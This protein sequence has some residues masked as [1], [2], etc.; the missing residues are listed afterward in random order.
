[1]AGFPIVI[2]LHKR[3]GKFKDN[4]ELRYTLRS[5][6]RHFKG[7]CQVAIVSEKLPVW[8]EGIEHIP[9]GGKGLKTALIRAAERF[10]G[11]FFWWYDDCVLLQDQ[12][13]AQLMVTPACKGWSTAK[14]AWAKSLDSIKER[15]IAEGRHAIDF[16]RPH[17]PY[18]LTKSMIDEA[19]AD[20][21]GMGGKFP[22]ESWILS[23]RGWPRRHA[24]VRQYYG[25]F[26]SPP[27]PASVFMNWCDRGFTPPLLKWLG[28]RF[29][30]AGRYEVK[31]KPVEIHCLRF[32]DPWWMKLCAPTLDAWC[33][34][35]GYPLRIWGSG[36]QPSAKFCMVDMLREFLKGNS[37]RMALVDA[38]VYVAENAPPLPP[39][40]TGFCI[41]EDMPGT[42]PQ[43]YTRWC[44]RNRI[45]TP[46]WVYRNSG[47]WVCDREAARR[48]LEFAVPPFI[49]GCQ[50]QHQ[51]NAWL[52]QA[53]AAGMQV[54]FLPPMWN[55]W[56]HETGPAAFCHLAGRRKARRL[57]QF[58]SDGRIPRDRPPEFVKAFDDQPYEFTRHT[59]KVEADDFHIHMLHVAVGLDTG[60][61]P[62]D[63]VAVEI[64][65]YRGRST[66][67]LVEALNRGLIGHLHIVETRPTDSLRQVLAMA[68]DPAKV[69]LHTKSYW[70]TEIGRVDF[71]FI[72]GDHKWTALAEALRAITWGT[73]IICVHD[74]QC[75]P[76][77]GD[78]WGAHLVGRMLK[79]HPDR[80]WL[81]D[82]QPRS[83][84]RTDRGLLVSVEKGIDLSPLRKFLEA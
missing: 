69:T 70:N 58:R 71:L 11:G 76:A 46:G 84:T 68:V 51:A 77:L 63:R 74:T 66:S 53:Q 21:P 80:E 10:P 28:D 64:G 73:R 13:P 50:E 41:R 47:V 42:G 7:E 48:L 36:S 5:I 30:E 49:E 39:G 4:T 24:V 15:L 57:E 78:M 3:G 23:K 20:W 45:R 14:T 59:L 31:E 40:L 81:E 43:G 17:G 19:F 61:P 44:R 62:G 26:R 55:A 27:P 34:K 12:S 33:Q 38:D 29:P 6:A 18:W 56:A 2:P 35:H 83:G 1:M 72:D 82:V 9:D 52:H 22:F 67:A 79:D 25:P 65:S 75:W 16:S 32:G 37:E 8:S 54:N 60:V